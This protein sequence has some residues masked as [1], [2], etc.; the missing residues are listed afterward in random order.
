M[1]ETETFSGFVF[2]VQ[3]GTEPETWYRCPLNGR[4]ENGG[5]NPGWAVQRGHKG[6]W[7]NI[8]QSQVPKDV[9]D[10]C[11]K[12]QRYEENLAAAHI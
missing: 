10:R 12:E 4:W 5:Y 1:T 8:P 9:V 7:F 11:V 3:N 6:V 2:K